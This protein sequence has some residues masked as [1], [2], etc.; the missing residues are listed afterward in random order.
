M[1]LRAIARNRRNCL[2]AITA[3]AVIALSGVGT[4]T[5]RNA[6]YAARPRP[7]RW[8]VP[9]HSPAPGGDALAGVTITGPSSLGVRVTGS[10]VATDLITGAAMDALGAPMDFAR[11]TRM[12]VARTG[13]ALTGRHRSG[14]PLARAYITSGFGSRLHPVLGVRRLHRGIDLAAPVGTPVIAPGSGM[15][16]VANWNGGY[17]LFVEIDHGDGFKSRY[18]HMSQLNVFP[19]Q[20]LQGGEVIG[21]VGATGRLTGPHL[22][23]ETIKAGRAVDPLR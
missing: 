16:T 7:E 13:V 8:I 21:L 20:R 18:G 14:L 22:H 17:G 11:F 6:A 12:Q 9:A 2:A 4:A 10:T 19:G 3:A 15:V 1:P 5:A 23:Y